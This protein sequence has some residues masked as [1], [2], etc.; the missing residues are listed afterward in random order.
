MCNSIHTASSPLG[1]DGT[2]SVP[3]SSSG[4]ED[5]GRDGPCSS[6]VASG[7]SYAEPTHQ[8]ARTAVTIA[9]ELTARAK[10]AMLILAVQV[11]C[12]HERGQYVIM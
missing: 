10:I 6:V 4:L 11:D 1:L 5:D 3:A 2:I 9:P 12:M 8:K 7:S